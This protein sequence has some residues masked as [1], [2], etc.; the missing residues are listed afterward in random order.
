[1]QALLKVKDLCVEFEVEGGTIHAVEGVS[2]EV[3]KGETLGLVGESG[4]G[5]S[6]TSLAITRLLPSPPAFIRRGEILFKNQDI[7]SM[8]VSDL[9]RLRGKSISYI[10]QDPIASLNPVFSIGNQLMEPL[11]FHKKMSHSQAKKRALDLLKQVGIPYPEEKIKAYPHQLSGGQCQRVMIAMAISCEPE[12]LIADEPTTALDVTI[13]LHIMDLLKELQKEYKMSM[14]F[15][16]HD[17]NLVQNI[18]D[19]CVVMY[20]GKAVEKGPMRGI[21]Q[22]PRSS[23]TRALI[24]S[25]PTLNNPYSRLPTIENFMDKGEEVSQGQKQEPPH[26]EKGTFGKGSLRWKERRDERPKR[27][28][29]V[30]LLEVQDLNRFFPVKSG[31]FQRTVSHFKAVKDVSFQ[32]FPGETLGLVG[33]SGCGKTTLSRSLLRLIPPTSGKILY[34]G[35]DLCALSQREL[36]KMRR[37]MQII[38]QSPYTSL[39]PRMTVQNILEEPLKVHQLCSNR[40]EHHQKVKELLD[41]VQLPQSCLDRYPHEFSGGQRQRI[42]IA[43]ALAVEPEFI[44]CD[45]PVSS[46]DVSIQAQIINLLLDIQEEM[47]LT[48][49][50]ISHDLAV[51]Q[52]ISDRIMVMH[53]GEIVESAGSQELYNTPQSPHTK[54]LLSSIPRPKDWVE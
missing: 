46:L 48:Y 33:D 50:F 5:K 7:F 28:G 19:N 16:S 40:W 38:F 36:Q 10:F 21:V 41:K 47:Q 24:A 54:K 37:K 13:Q 35:K 51:V 31:F 22:R 17:L 25:R 12:L 2:F 8:K 43:R 4:S 27:I 29:T 34:K 26:E 32:V 52:F 44:V 53:S 14:L 45:E 20:Q 42:S 15:I 18:A 3:E 11:L 23:Y 6:V 9:H 1:M 39:N 30:P 49:I